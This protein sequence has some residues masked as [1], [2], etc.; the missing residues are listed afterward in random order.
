[1]SMMLL[2]TL[3]QSA[4]AIQTYVDTAACVARPAVHLDVG[5]GSSIPG[6]RVLLVEYPEPGNDP[7]ARGAFAPQDKTAGRSSEMG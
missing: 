1:M 2:L 4:I 3:A 7:A 5:R 6:E